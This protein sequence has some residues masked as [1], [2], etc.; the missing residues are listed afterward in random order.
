MIF[1]SKI[2]HQHPLIRGKR[3]YIIETIRDFPT[4]FNTQTI[5]RMTMSRFQ[6]S[7]TTFYRYLRISK[8]FGTNIEEVLTNLEELGIFGVNISSERT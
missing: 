8:S 7:T 4:S 6:I 3:Q 5:K 2:N 1:K